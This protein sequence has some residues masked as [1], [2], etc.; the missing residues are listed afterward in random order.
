ML[1]LAPA[2]AGAA[3]GQS[4]ASE[5][6]LLASEQST[7]NAWPTT[8]SRVVS[9]T[10]RGCVSRWRMRGWT[11]LDFGD[12]ESGGG[13]GSR[14]WG[15]HAH[16]VPAPGGTHAT[17]P[18]RRA[19]QVPPG[20]GY[21]AALRQSCPMSETHSFNFELSKLIKRSSYPE[22]GAASERNCATP[23]RGGS[24][25]ETRGVFSFLFLSFCLEI[26][27]HSCNGDH[28]TLAQRTHYPCMIKG[29]SLPAP[30]FPTSAGLMWI[31]IL[32]YV[33]WAVLVWSIV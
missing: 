19:R 28:A 8:S 21:K 16:A 10:V 22:N 30:G 33:V 20:A 2:L 24:P 9:G 15:W 17:Q 31:W 3:K 5:A 18:S 7:E 14:T 11:G 26:H 23:P 6:A 32:Y 12:G 25:K 27:S 13:A 1:R 29:R 4:R